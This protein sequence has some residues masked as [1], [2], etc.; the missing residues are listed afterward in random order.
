MF[1]GPT[2]L[3]I[4]VFQDCVDG[5]RARLKVVHDALVVLAYCSCDH[6]VHVD[7]PLLCLPNLFLYRTQLIPLYLRR[8]HK[9]LFEFFN[10][11]PAK[12]HINHIFDCYEIDQLFDFF[13]NRTQNFPVFFIPVYDSLHALLRQLFTFDGGEAGADIS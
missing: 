12:A 7:Y 13:D 10:V 6:F 3:H 11:H 1:H 9:L 4:V 2:I 5:G 8:M